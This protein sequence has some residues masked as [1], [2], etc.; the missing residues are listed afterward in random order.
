MGIDLHTHSTAS[1]GTYSPTDLARM[2]SD[3][4]LE[5]FALT[6]HD[7]I[8]GVNEALKASEEIGI[9]C[10]PGV[11]ISVSLEK[12]SAHMLGYLFDP[13]DEAFGV[14]LAEFN[15]S[16]NERNVKILDNLHKLGID[17]S[18]EDVLRQKDDNDDEGALGRP[19]FAKA[20]I[21]KGVVASFDEAFDRYLG[22]NRPAYAERRRATAEDAIAIIHSAGGLAVLAHPKWVKAKGSELELLVE[23]L[24]SAGLD[25]LEC[26]YTDHSAEQTQTYLKLAERLGLLVTGGSDFHGEAKPDARLG[27]GQGNLNIPYELLQRLKDATK[28]R[29]SKA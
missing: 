12:G 15:D 8:S 20:L 9:E 14:S 11:E 21:E 16:R 1:D 4:G 2:V 27:V 23:S 7:T 19:H 28:A 3:A 10:I 18:L 25:G 22:K 26:H 17:L 29:S 13:A 6:D 24:A 5:A